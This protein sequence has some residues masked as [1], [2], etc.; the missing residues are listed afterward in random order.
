MGLPIL[1]GPKFCS[2]D[3]N[4]LAAHLLLPATIGRLI[5]AVAT[6]SRAA[7]AAAAAETILFTNSLGGFRADHKWHNLELLESSGGQL[8]V[9]ASYS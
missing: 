4:G 6:S 2:P 7:L 1:P 9:L 3:L 5:A 8:R